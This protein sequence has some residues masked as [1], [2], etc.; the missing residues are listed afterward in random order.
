M[1]CCI[2]LKGGLMSVSKALFVPNTVVDRG[3][4]LVA[5]LILIIVGAIIGFLPLALIQEGGGLQSM[6]TVTSVS[7]LVYVLI[8][9]WF[10]TI[11]GRLRDAGAS[12]WFFLLGLFGYAVVS[13]VLGMIFIMPAMAGMMEGVIENIP[14]T[15]GDEAEAVA[16]MMD[17]QVEMMRQM[18]PAQAIAGSVA[19]F[20]TAAVFWFLPHKPGEKEAMVE[21]F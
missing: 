1:L 7:M 17:M 3:T 13:S 2:Q 15:E 9:P 21:T 4:Y 10:C 16:Q 6:M 20:L 5:A 14:D 12:P 8:Y 18:L 19:S 11:A